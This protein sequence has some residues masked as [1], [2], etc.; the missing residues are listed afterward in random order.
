MDTIQIHSGNGEVPAAVRTDGEHDRIKSLFA[1]L[2]DG[3]IAPGS[4]IHF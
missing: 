2:P 1:Q 4:L 3:E